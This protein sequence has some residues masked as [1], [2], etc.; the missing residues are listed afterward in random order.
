[1]TGKKVGCPCSLVS[2]SHFQLTEL[3]IKA[4]PPCFQYGRARVRAKWR[5]NYTQKGCA[6]QMWGMTLNATT[7][8]DIQGATLRRACKS[9]TTALNNTTPTPCMSRDVCLFIH[10]N[11]GG[12]KRRRLKIGCPQSL[13]GNSTTQ[14][15]LGQFLLRYVPLASQIPYPMI[16]YSVAN[17]RFHFSHFWANM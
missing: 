17:Y 4:N 8:R 7:Q 16:V 12:L 1:M 3:N 14:G 11:P 15:D 5:I 9:K 13:N 2:Y 10:S 6:M